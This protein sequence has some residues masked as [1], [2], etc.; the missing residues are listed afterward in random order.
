MK[1]R[2]SLVI[3]MLL[4]TLGSVWAQGPGVIPIKKL[5][6]DS[7]GEPKS[8]VY[9]P[10]PLVSLNGTELFFTFSSATTSQ[11]IIMDQCNANQV[12]YSECFTSSTQVN[13]DLE[14][15]GIGKGSYLLWLF[16]FGEWWEGEFVIEEE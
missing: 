10:I 16:A 9:S 7:I 6:T 5:P 1:K 13:V 12:V 3:G 8:P 4:L 14:D 11:V 2:I 15:E